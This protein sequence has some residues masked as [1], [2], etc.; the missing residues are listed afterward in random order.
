VPSRLFALDWFANPWEKLEFSGAFFSGQNVAHFGALRQGF[1]I[2][3]NGN[4]IPVHSR[5]G[6][7][8][9]SFPFTSRVTLNIFGGVHDDRNRDLGYD[10]IAANRTGAANL[11]YRL[12]PNVILS[13][14]ALQMRT[15]YLEIG[16]R[17]NNRYD[18][19]VAYLF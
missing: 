13:I 16:T 2:R 7:G 15:T 14:E 18:L 3:R 11:M 5:G 8:Q 10:G 17:H 1:T 19:A 9:L 12:A 4:V 6:W